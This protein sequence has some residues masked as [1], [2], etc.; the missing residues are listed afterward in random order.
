MVTPAAEGSKGSGGGKVC[1]K[2]MKYTDTARMLQEYETD[3][4][5]KTHSTGQ[6]E[7]TQNVRRGLEKTCEN[8]EIYWNTTVSHDP[9]KSKE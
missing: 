2:Q 6:S 1:G 7:R 8:C 9:L 5:L 3:K 4:E